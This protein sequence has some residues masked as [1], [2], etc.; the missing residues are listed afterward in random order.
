M[1]DNAKDLMLADYLD[2]KITRQQV[3]RQFP[4]VVEELELLDLSIQALGSLPLLRTNKRINMPASISAIKLKQKKYWY[5]AASVML[6]AVTTVFFF[7]GHKK[8]NTNFSAHLESNQT[9]EKLIA[10]VEILQSATDADKYQYQL[11]QL[12]TKD[13]NSNIRY[14]AL[15][16]LVQLPVHL[17]DAE[18]TNF[19]NAE[20]IFTNQTVWLELWIKI[21]PTANSELLQWLNKEDINP[22]VKNYGVSLLKS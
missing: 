12:S 8:D 22:T 1:E 17:S 19:I 14:M 15:E 10:L 5:A 13:K 16:K 6:I 9:E 18:L 20:Q 2:G 11:L 21:H 7:L 4:D 3:L